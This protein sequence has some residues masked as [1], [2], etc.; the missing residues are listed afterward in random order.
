MKI[1]SKS[2][3]VIHLVFICLTFTLFVNCSGTNTFIQDQPSQIEDDNNSDD[4]GNSENKGSNNDGNSENNN[5][6]N[7]N[8]DNNNNN[9]DDNN[10][11]NNDNLIS[12][13][14]AAS[15]A[16]HGGYGADGQAGTSDDPHI[17]STSVN[18]CE[19]L[20]A[21]GHDD[22]ENFNFQTTSSSISQSNDQV[23]EVVQSG[24][25]CCVRNESQNIDNEDD[26]DDSDEDDSTIDDNFLERV[27]DAPNMKHI[28]DQLAEQCPVIMQAV[29]D[30]AK[31]TWSDDLRFLDLAVEA[32][33]E[34]DPRWGYTF[35]TRTGYEDSWSVDRVGYFHGTGNPHDSTDITVIDY[36]AP[37]QE[38]G[39]WVYYSSWYDATEQLKRDYPDATGYWKFPRPGATVSLSDCSGTSE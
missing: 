14:S 36:L 3:N 32:L 33:R 8:D 5:N 35:W 10:N 18:S 23:K 28:I 1:Q 39:K 11:N 7:N 22:W 24:G 27:E 38:D 34:E 37:R 4:N 19:E 17:Y 25:V 9:N 15:L 16:G 26:S 21:F 30:Q 2:I 31:G 12:C 20:E 13:G 6:N 29:F